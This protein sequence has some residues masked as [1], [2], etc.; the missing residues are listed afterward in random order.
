MEVIERVDLVFT[1]W[2][3]ALP[4]QI[5][6]MYNAEESVGFQDERPLARKWE[7]KINALRKPEAAPAMPSLPQQTPSVPFELSQV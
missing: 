3:Q 6:E 4:V 1:P 5:L 7:R 2:D